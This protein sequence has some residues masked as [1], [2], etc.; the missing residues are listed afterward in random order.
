MEDSVLDIISQ[1]PEGAKEWCFKVR[2]FW[3]E[4]GHLM[5]R[6]EKWFVT[7]SGAMEWIK[8]WFERVDADYADGVWTDDPP[9]GHINSLNTDSTPV[10]TYMLRTWTLNHKDEDNEDVP[11]PK[12]WVDANISVMPLF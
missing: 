9:M 8:G 2:I 5:K 3:R 4:E 1:L 7:H 10:G 12:D 6:R 11:R